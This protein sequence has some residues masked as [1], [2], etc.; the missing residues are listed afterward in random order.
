M[1]LKVNIRSIKVVKYKIIN[2]C[3]YFYYCLNIFYCNL[4]LN[5][6]YKHFRGYYF[7][8]LLP[9]KRF[10]YFDFLK[11]SSYIFIQMPT[12]DLFWIFKILNLNNT[13]NILCVGRRN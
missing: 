7:D 13:S 3:K 8:S 10:F 11:N 1:F 4:T 5:L 2:E 6:T 9:A 12:H